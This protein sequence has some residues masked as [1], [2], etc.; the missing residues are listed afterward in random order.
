MYKST[1]GG[2]SWTHIGLEN[3]RQVHRVI[4]HPENPDIVWAGTMGSAWA[5]NPERGVYK[6]VDGGASWTQ[7]LYINDTTGVADLR[8]DPSNPNRL[9]C[10]MWHHLREPWFFKS[11]GE[12]SGLYITNDGGDNWEQIECGSGIPCGELGRIGVAFAPSNSDVVYAYIESKENAVYRSDDGGFT[13]K[14]KSKSKQDIGGR[15]F[16]YADIYVDVKNE[17]RLYSIATEVTTSDDAGVTWKTFAAGNRVHT[18]HHAW[19][20]HPEN[21]DHLING[22]DGGLFYTNDRGENWFFVENLPL[23]QFYHMRVDNEVP[24]NVYGGLQDNGSWCGPSQTWFKGG[25]RNMYWQR[26]SVGDGFDVVP[27]PQ[28]HNYGYAMAA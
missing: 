9:I 13:W 10:A 1:D 19:W 7:V 27:D 17:N 16:Y 14:R 24:Y 11:G 18:D 23:A 4:V 25:I 26:L 3:T 28:D 22:N 21:P 6:S 15:P 5:P 2:R 20:A 12:G 8:L